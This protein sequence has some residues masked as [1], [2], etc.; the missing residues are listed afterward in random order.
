[1]Y[2]AGVRSN[3]VYR[4]R[5]HP[6]LIGVAG[7]SGAGK[8]TLC[9]LLADVLG[10][11]RLTVING[12][13]YHRW[14]RGHEKWQVYTHLNI[15]GSD[16]HQ[17]AEHA[18]A[19]YDG[20]TIVKGVYDHAT[21]Q[22]ANPQ[23]VD[24]GEFIVFSGLHSLSLD[25][26]RRLFDL[27]VFLDPDENLRRRWKLGRDQR[28]RGYAPAEAASTLDQR[29]PDRHAYILPQRETADVV[30]SLKPADGGATALSLELRALNGF[31]LAGLAE[32][33]AAAASLSVEHHPFL[34]SRWQLLEVRGAISAERLQ[35][36]CEAH[37]P[38]LHE[39]APQ[40]RFAD[41]LNGVAQAALLV[42]LSNRLRWSSVHTMNNEQ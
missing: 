22:F 2:L 16:V 15:R 39:I 27:K 13:D 34:D 38:N 7:D 24:A 10:E 5:S 11:R 19:M 30:I 33:L 8:T 41:G 29:A 32:D 28:E 21:G 26:M 35:E 37:V 14:P 40:P 31:A 17:Q 6:V 36:I 1:M 20:K 3:A 9:R 23:E 42:C 4:M 18:I 12:D 25:T